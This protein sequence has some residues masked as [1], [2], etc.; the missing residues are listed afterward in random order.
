MWCR[1]TLY[2]L[3]VLLTI[4]INW[5]IHRVD[6]SCFFHFHTCLLQYFVFQIMRIECSFYVT[7]E[8][9]F[10]FIFFLLWNKNISIYR[11][12]TLHFEFTQKTIHLKGLRKI[13]R[14]RQKFLS[15]LLKKDGIWNKKLINQFDEM[16]VTNLQ[17]NFP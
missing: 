5:F 15:Y 16:L 7:F 1:N 2:V 10:I 3:L 4:Y 6:G 13:L 12:L 17:I 14:R 11:R 8:D 9:I